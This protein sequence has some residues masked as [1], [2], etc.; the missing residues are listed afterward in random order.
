MIFFSHLTHP[1]ILLLLRSPTRPSFAIGLS[2]MKFLS[3]HQLPFD[4]KDTLLDPATLNVSREGGSMTG[5]RPFTDAIGRID[6][7]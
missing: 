4:T 1:K 5:Q 3:L 2:R 6:R 7:T